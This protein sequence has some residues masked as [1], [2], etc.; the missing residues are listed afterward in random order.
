MFSLQE[1][2]PDFGQLCPQLA[3]LY[4]T[5]WVF[6][7]PQQTQEGQ[8][9]WKQA[10][11]KNLKHIQKMTIPTQMELLHFWLIWSYVKEKKLRSFR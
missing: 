11:K 1:M 9:K 6:N 3:F 2:S 8:H 10:E 5:P 7:N 4:L